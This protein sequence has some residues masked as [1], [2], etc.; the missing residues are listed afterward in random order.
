MGR[1]Q[2]TL[3]AFS[4]PSRSP[5]MSSTP[6]VSPTGIRIWQQNLNKS[7]VAHEDLINSDAH[8]NFDLLILQE[9][10]IDTLGNTK[11]TRNWRVTYPS[12]HLSD[13]RPSRSVI[14]VST[15]INT[16]N[17]SQIHIPDTHDVVAIQVSGPHG[18]LN[19]FDIY[20][21][22]LNADTIDLLGSFLS[23]PHHPAPSSN[24]NPHYMLWCGDFNR[25]HPMW[26]KE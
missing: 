12:S 20:N 11:A 13:S 8:K 14:L 18:I 1:L 3:T 5:R 9:P 22:C 19:I 24:P 17:W 4:A 2:L 26:D 23:L 16:N 25:H 6:T 10:F 21:D 7:R 15:S